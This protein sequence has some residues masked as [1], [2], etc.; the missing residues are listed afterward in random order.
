MITNKT[1]PL[2]GFPRSGNTFLRYSLREMYLDHKF[3]KSVHTENF[4]EM[5]KNY[6]YIIMTIRKPEESV[7]S[8]TQYCYE[9]EKILHGEDFPA[10]H[11]TPESNLKYYI[12]YH[13]KIMENI[14][15]VIVLDFYKFTEDFSYAIEKIKKHIGIEPNMIVD[16]KDIFSTI[17]EKEGDMYTPR[18]NKQELLYIKNKVILDPFLEK[19]NEIYKSII[20]ISESQDQ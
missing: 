13:E 17:F 9:V 7:S 3:I 19:A 1:I 11:T 8:W 12:R 2:F 5:H 6:E 15:N 14:K 4:I 20:S 18:D 10:Q 16:K